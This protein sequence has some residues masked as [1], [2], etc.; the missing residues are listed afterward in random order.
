M[1]YKTLTI[2]IWNKEIWDKKENYNKIIRKKL[3]QKNKTN[4]K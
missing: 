3:K 1:K 4:K 2:N